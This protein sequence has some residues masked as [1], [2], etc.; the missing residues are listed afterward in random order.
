MPFAP[1]QEAT[2]SYT[3]K[4]TLVT[5]TSLQ[6]RSAQLVKGG[7]LYGTSNDYTGLGGS[8]A[9]VSTS[10]VTSSAW[11]SRDGWTPGGPRE[12]LLPTN[13]KETMKNLNDRLASYMD[14][15]R[16]L[17]E[18]NNDLASKIREWHAKR[19]TTAK[20]D[21]SAYEKTIA[22]LQAQIVAGRLNKARIDIQMDNAKLAADDFSTK[23]DNEKAGRL[24]LEADIER[25]RK[26]LDD[27]TIMKTDLE[28]EIEGLRKDLICMKKHHEEEMD[29][30][31]SQ[32]RSSD[33]NVEVDASPSRE[34][35]ALLKEVREEYE[36]IID[37]YRR[38]AAIWL[39]QQAQALQHE[40]FTDSQAVEIDNK[41]EL[42]LKRIY[43]NLQIEF[44][45]ELSRKLSLERNLEETQCHFAEELER[46]QRTICQM[47]AELSDLRDEL[48]RQQIERQNLM[49]LKTRLENEIATYRRLIEGDDFGRTASQRGAN[50]RRSVKTIVQDYVDGRVVS[51]KVKEI[52]QKA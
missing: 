11:Q 51:S 22:D 27:M 14:K 36:A 19:A 21:Y 15:V 2:M 42:E 12:G 32:Q 30:L 3:R 31:R 37:K 25:V 44:Q 48:K 6:G 10:T 45:A 40:E 29:A 43:Q 16:E 9:S 35:S 18:G 34:L 8:K 1:A 46:K 24:S 49:D 28:M 4:T 20:R 47:E 5:S 13:E 23:Y 50:G 52:H 41:E 33:V 7:N 39:Q 17:E 38:E 26:L